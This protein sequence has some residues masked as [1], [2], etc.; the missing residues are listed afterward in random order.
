[1]AAMPLAI[2]MPSAIRT[3][4][5]RMTHERLLRENERALLRFIRQAA[6]AIHPDLKPLLDK[7][8]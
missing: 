6:N 4:I 8:A 2:A 5:E 3:T 1:M 7:A